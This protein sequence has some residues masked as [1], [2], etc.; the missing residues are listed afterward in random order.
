M[1]FI[2]TKTILS[3]LKKSPEPWFGITYNMNLYRG[4]QHQCIYCDSR[5][6]CYQIDDFSKIQ[7]KE[8]ALY[9]LENEIKRKK[10]KGTIGT[11]SMN[12]PYMPLEKTSKMVR[13]ALEIIAKNKYPVHII[14][15]SN[16][17]LR[18][19]D[20]IKNIS[21]TYAAVSLTITTYDDE[22][23]K[24]IEPG[25]PTT[26]ERFAAL[27]ELSDNG[28]YCGVLLM[29]VLPFIN[30]TVENITN[31]IEKTALNGGKYII[32]W[33]GMTL[34]DNQRDYYYKALDK[35]FPGI[36]ESYKSRYKEQYSVSVPDSL[37]LQNTFNSTC[38]K[39]N[40]P[41]KMEFFSESK[42]E[43]LSLF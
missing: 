28:I 26:S 40:L 3:K 36:S 29:P 12:D 18:D 32:G 14:T 27:K 5:S 42:P 22:L 33:M 37:V 30:D 1:E 20:L 35:Y 24:I 41:T 2:Q 13:G 38:K 31:I 9:L 6:K 21:E 25:A 43:Q 16:L 11:G 23:S 19:I 17:V 8:N 15:K 7:V 10:Q 34:R 4:C 39:F